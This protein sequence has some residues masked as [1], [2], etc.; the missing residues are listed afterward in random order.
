MDEQLKNLIAQL[1]AAGV[2]TKAFQK[3]FDDTSRTIGD[4]E[5]LLQTMLSTLRGVQAN[6]RGL[7]GEFGNIRDNLAAALAE[8]QKKNAAINKATRNYK[9]LTGIVEQLAQ[10]EEGLITLG[11]KQLDVLRSKASINLQEM[12]LNAKR[13]IQEKAAEGLIL[14]QNGLINKRTEGYKNLSDRIVLISL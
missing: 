1:K 11:T 7:S 10:E 6:A 4:S 14:N 9:G 13:L 2:D 8:L 12:Q 3:A 5:K